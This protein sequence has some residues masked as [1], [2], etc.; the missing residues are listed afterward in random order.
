MVAPKEGITSLFLGFT[1]SA[2]AKILAVSGDV[3]GDVILH[4]FTELLVDV[5]FSALFVQLTKL[6]YTDF[7][8]PLFILSCIISPSYIVRSPPQ[9]IFNGYK[10][11]PFFDCIIMH[12]MRLYYCTFMLFPNFLYYNHAINIL[13]DRSLCTSIIMRIHFYRQD[14]L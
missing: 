11:I 4:L 2:S 7:L 5:F 8:K 14:H 1:N 3:S 9:L 13:E 10:N 6:D 12:L